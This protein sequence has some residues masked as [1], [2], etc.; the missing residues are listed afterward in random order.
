MKTF[1]LLSHRFKMIGF[2]LMGMA[3]VWAIASSGAT[4]LPAFLNATVPALIGSD[5][6]NAT[7]W[8]TTVEVNLSYTLNGLLFIVGG[9]LVAFS[10]E[11]QEDEYLMQL[12][13]SAF[14]WAVFANYILLLVLFLGVYGIDFLVVLSYHLYTVIVL[15]IARFHYLLYIN[16]NALNDEK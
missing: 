16:R 10:R 1:F 14:Q 12:R 15:F 9:L 11:N 5:V 3:V 2:V 4:T 6:H 8:F 7:V 13:L